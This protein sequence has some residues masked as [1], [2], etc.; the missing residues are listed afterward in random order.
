MT[1]NIIAKHFCLFALIFLIQIPFEGN[2]AA[3]ESRQ[4]LLSEIMFNPTGSDRTD[5]FIE[6]YNNSCYII[7]LSTWQVGDEHAT[8]HIIN[9]GMGTLLP[10]HNYCVIADKDGIDLHSF[11][12]STIPDS[13]L[14]VT[15]N[16]N[17]LGS[18]GLSN[19]TSERIILISPSGDTVSKTIYDTD[20]P[21]G[22]SWERIDFKSQ[23]ENSLWSPSKVFGGTPGAANS[24]SIK[25]S[26]KIEIIINPNPFSPNNDGFEDIVEIKYNISLGNPVVTLRVFDIKGRLVNVLLNTFFS[27]CSFSLHWDG[28]DFTGQNLPSGIYIIHLEVIDFVC[29]KKETFQKCIVIAGG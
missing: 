7:D 10:P 25:P 5:E 15:T 26:D 6:I 18:R 13:A 22:F 11:Y 29:G 1:F 12:L 2:L 4:L 23:E 14:I 28:K 8:N 20:T 19:S 24:V 3:Q 16:G 27:P 21:E 17:T 9:A